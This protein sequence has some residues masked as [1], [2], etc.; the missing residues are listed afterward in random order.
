MQKTFEVQGPVELDVRLASGDIEVDPS[1]EGRVE[2]ELVAHD[3]ESQRLIDN[4]RIELNPHGHRPTVLVDVPQKRGFSISIFG[5]SGIECRIRCPH[6]SG[7][8]VRTKSADI[9]TRGTLGGLNVATASGDLD[10]DRV[11][12]GVN[13]KSASSDFTAREV[14]GGVNI[15]T[16]SGDIDLSI[17]RG[18]VNVTS[19]SGDISIGE[20]YDNVNANSV[21]GDQDHGAVMQGIV[22]A[23]SVSGDVTIAVRRGSK[24]FLDCTTVSGDTTSELELTSDAPAGEGPLVEIRAKTVSGD[25]RITRAPAPADTQEVH[26]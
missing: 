2:V 16:A 25:I 19:V 15:Q 4:A 7:L 13:V 12:G 20:A 6:D 5:R 26:A 22:A 14:A 17:A 8:A 10:I 11:S 23:H 24:A 9:S 21:S 3:E 18:P 1:A